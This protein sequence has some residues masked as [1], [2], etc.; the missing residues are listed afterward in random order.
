MLPLCQ[1]HAYNEE[2]V[3]VSSVKPG[4][5][6]SGKKQIVTPGFVLFNKVCFRTWAAA[7]TVSE[8]LD[9]RFFPHKGAQKLRLR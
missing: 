6:I 5:V 3:V 2:Q 9:P 4:E 8:F 1:W 7:S